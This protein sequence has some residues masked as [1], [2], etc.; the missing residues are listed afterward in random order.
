MNSILDEHAPLKRVN[1]HKLNLK[2][3]PW[4]TP[5]IQKSTSVKNN[6]LRFLIQKIHK[7]RILFM[8]NAKIIEICYLP[9]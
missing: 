6:L 1:K 2:G 5:A 3:K 7:Q 4:I 9:F 8:S